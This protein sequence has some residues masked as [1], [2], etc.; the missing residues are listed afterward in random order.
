VDDAGGL[1]LAGEGGVSGNERVGMGC[2][3]GEA[4]EE[5]GVV[6]GGGSGTM[7]AAAARIEQRSNVMAGPSGKSRK[8]P[9]SPPSS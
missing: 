7:L 2:L 3:F 4:G 1:R 8:V 9:S 5:V 6:M